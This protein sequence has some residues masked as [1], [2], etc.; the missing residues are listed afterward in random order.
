MA[1]LLAEKNYLVGA[2]GRRKEHLE[3]LRSERSAHVLISDFDVTSTFDVSTKLDELAAQ[4][5]GLDLLIISSGVGEL[6]D[7]LDFAIE[8]NTIDVNVTGFTAAADWAFN[9]FR[10]QGTGHLVAIT[11]I[12]GL[13]GSRQAPAYNATKAFQISYLE[14]LRQ[15]AG[16]LQIPV[17]VTDIRPGFVDTAMA[18]GEGKF[19]VAPVEKAARQILAAIESRKSVAYITSRW[20][21]I[22]ALLKVLPRMIYNRM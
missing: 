1:V 17:Y 13:R 21:T 18:K 7:N 8:K 15:K 3:E 11:S 6:N 19:W 10:K 4:L 12:A 22:A 5:G 9:F 20:R 14:G 16:N 2:T